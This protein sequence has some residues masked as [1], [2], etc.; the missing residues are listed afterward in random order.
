[1]AD[2][3]V[4][5]DVP[6]G[7]EAHELVDRL[8]PRVDFVKVGLELFIGEGPQVVRTLRG[9]DLRVFLDLKLHDIPNTV[10]AA[11]RSASALGV[12]LLTLH[13]SGGRRMLEAAVAARSGSLKLL[14]VTVL[15]SLDAGEVDQA[16]G[17]EGADPTAEAVRLARLAH[18]AGVDGVVSSPLEAARIRSAIGDAH[19]V[20]PGIRLAGSGRSDQRRVAT[21]ADAVRAGASHL[22]VG[23]TVTAAEDPAAAFD[24][25]RL[26]VAEAVAEVVP[27]E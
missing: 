4:A 17:R 12:E 23:R 26:E 18:D 27:C 6:S 9:R 25:V 16:W 11:V 8:G 1:M 5:L 3:I 13:A 14:G 2:I 20:T 15:T 21:P 10:A 19:M 24:R 7:R 22:V